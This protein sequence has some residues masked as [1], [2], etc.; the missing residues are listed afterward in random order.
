MA[1][2]IQFAG[3]DKWEAEIKQQEQ[4]LQIRVWK[5]QSNFS[6][7]N[8]VSQ[9]RNAFVSMQA[10]AQHV[11]YQLPNEHSRVV[12]LL[13]AIHCSDAGLQAATASVRTS[14]GPQGLRNNF[15]TTASD[16]LPYDP[17][18]RKRLSTH[19]R[20][21]LLISGEEGEVSAFNMTKKSGIGKTG[22]HFRFYKKPEYDKLSDEQKVELKEWREDNP[23]TVKRGKQ[24]KLKGKEDKKLL[25]S[26]KEIAS[27]VSKKVKLALGE[28]DSAGKEEEETSAYIMSL[29]EKA[30]RK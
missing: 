21:N 17:V 22:V 14:N 12:F 30:L 4:L 3:T 11:Q 8:F 24:E 13:D 7:E 15:E 2:V 1:L 28:K 10:C 5:G 18:A 26:K 27:Q 23:D 25:Y 29:V 9:H 16:L 19:K 20:Q 6:R